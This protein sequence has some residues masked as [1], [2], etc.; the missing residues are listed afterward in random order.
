MPVRLRMLCFTAALYGVVE[1]LA[2]GQTLLPPRNEPVAKPVPEAS[3]DSPASQ[4]PV[5]PEFIPWWENAAK[6][7]LKP[8]ANPLNMQL[9]QAVL[10]TLVHSP[11]LRVAADV[12]L[13]RHTTIQQA[14]ARFDVQTFVDS[15]FTD[16]SDPVGNL[17]TTGGAPRFIDQTLAHST[18]VRRTARSGAQMEVAQRFGY[19]DNNSIYFVPAPQG[20]SRIAM[21][22]TQPLLNGRGQAYNT[23]LV[24]L[25]EVQTGKADS[26]LQGELQNLLLEVHQAYWN[27]YL[28]R[29]IWLQKQ[30]LYD[31]AR[32]IRDDLHGRRDFD[33]LKN[34][35]V[36]AEAAVA[37]REA[38][39]IRLRTSIDNAETRLRALLNDP[40]L[41]VAAQLE[42]IPID[43]PQR[44]LY[45][46]DQSYVLSQALQNRP[47]IQVAF[48]EIRAASV[49][50]DVS[51]HEMMP[52][53][54]FVLSSYVSGLAGQSDVG[55]A[56]VNQFTLGR[57]TYAAGLQFEM[58][59]GR[60]AASARLQQR[61]IELRQATN[62]LQEISIQVRMEA[63]IAAREQVTTY[64]EMIS[65]QHAMRAAEAE[66]DFLTDRWKLL[67]GDQQMGGIML[68]NLLQAHE[69]LANAEQEFAIAEAAYNVSLVALQRAMGTLVQA[70]NVRQTESTENGLPTLQFGSA[71]PPMPHPP[72]PPPPPQDGAMPMQPSP[73]MS[74]PQAT[75]QQGTLPPINGPTIGGGVARLPAVGT[76]P[77][78]YSR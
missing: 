56:W 78:F 21:T 75:M 76:P 33:V 5:P 51:K 11:R 65:R 36:R 54:N 53:L 15:K 60:R 10:G 14:D 55:Q 44:G 48:K 73:S 38:A 12:P 34:Q 1:S 31:R 67:P 35:I 47:E 18:G 8:N 66:V 25:A 41:T 52:V 62:H 24:L 57:P 23:S 42:L 22:V 17:L 72:V 7:P 46:P 3:A 59:W 6:G 50:A 27:L 71:G 69:R 70:Q 45:E 20:T 19:Q 2:L 30:R 13:A 32:V 4:Q 74:P 39:V 77:A 28:Q 9:D 68:D 63:D 40:Q 58:P 61:M 49:R 16:T 26:E 29:S 37:E 64:R 43:R